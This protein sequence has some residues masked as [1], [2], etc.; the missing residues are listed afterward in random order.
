M[1]NPWLAAITLL[2]W[3]P[4][5]AQD[6]EELKQRLLQKEAEVEALR[7][8]I[9]L[10][11][12][13]LTLRQATQPASPEEANPDDQDINRA[14]E[15]SLVREGGLV[16]PPKT[17]EFEPNFVY[18]HTTID[19]FRRDAFGPGLTFRAGLP[20]RSQLEVALPYVVEHRRSSGVYT[21]AS[22]I[23]DLSLTL[24]H[25]LLAERPFVPGLI[26]GFAYQ[27]ATG[28]NTIFESATPVALG[29]GFDAVQA[30][31][32]AVKRVDPLVFFGTYTF[33]HNIA[34]EKAGVE[35]DP[36]N[37]HSL[38]FGTI[39]ATSPTTSLRAVFNWALF[40]TTTYGGSPIAGSDTPYGLLELGGSVVLGERTA[41]DVAVGAGLT[42][43]APDFRI[44]VA[45]PIRF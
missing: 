19:D 24:S 11:E 27:A 6:L 8:R 44:S 45:L 17:F 28:K 13:Q 43:N 20:W 40:D 35:V 30:F 3:T 2:L 34:D 25:Q 31:L 23:G 4:L 37:S 22:G 10:L 32:T 7:T 42:R 5:F 16:L 9:Q 41:L 39:L 29:T 26:G 12:R 15:R 33:S 38:R 36:G 21:D 18:S 1:K 14:L